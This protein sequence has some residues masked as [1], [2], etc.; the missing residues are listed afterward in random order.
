MGRKNRELAGFPDIDGARPVYR[1][2]AGYPW[3]ALRKRAAESPSPRGF[4]CESRTKPCDRLPPPSPSFRPERPGFDPGRV[5]EES[6]RR[7]KGF[8]VGETEPRFLRY[9][10]TLWAGAPVGMTARGFAGGSFGGGAR[11]RGTAPTPPEYTS[12]GA[13]IG[14]GGER[15]RRPRGAPGA[16]R[17]LAGGDIG[18]KNRNVK[19]KNSK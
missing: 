18:D 19:E 1:K 3:I 7:T 8:L 9:A 10:P 2:F 15:E 12:G 5:A 4:L 16:I 13:G 11:G 6:Q 14:V 17:A